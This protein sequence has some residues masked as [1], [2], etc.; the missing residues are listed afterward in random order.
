MIESLADGFAAGIADWGTD[1]DWRRYTMSDLISD[2][3]SWAT[4]LEA[5]GLSPFARR[6]P[7]I[8]SRRMLIPVFGTTESYVERSSRSATT[9]P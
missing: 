8:S 6:R 2:T 7:A 4:A 1:D 3:S 5:Q 9:E